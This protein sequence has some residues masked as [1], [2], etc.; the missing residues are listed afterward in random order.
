[1]NFFSRRRKAGQATVEISERD[2]VRYMHL[3][4][5]AVQSAM[6][7]RDPYGLELEYTRRWWPRPGAI[8]CCRRTTS[9]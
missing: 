7:V 3:G 5:P 9:A 1:M 2:G 4:G 6:R 8:F